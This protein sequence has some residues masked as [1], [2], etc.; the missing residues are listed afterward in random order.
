V[1]ESLFNSLKMELIYRNKL[2]YK[3]QMKLKIFEYIEIWDN[4]KRRHYALNYA[5]IKECN[6]QI[7]YK[8]VAEVILELLFAYLLFSV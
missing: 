6:N 5:T 3:E 8:N 7:N 1:A 2:I 4:R